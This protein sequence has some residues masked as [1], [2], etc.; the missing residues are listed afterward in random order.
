MC[1][2]PYL[3]SAHQGDLASI[4]HTMRS[5]CACRFLANA[6]GDDQWISMAAH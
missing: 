1:L 3:V 5:T 6:G 4:V 2:M